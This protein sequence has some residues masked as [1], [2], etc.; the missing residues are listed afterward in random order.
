MPRG[1]PLTSSGCQFLAKY[2]T[3]SLFCLFGGSSASENVSRLTF[4]TSSGGKILRRGWTSNL[5]DLL[6]SESRGVRRTKYRG[7]KAPAIQYRKLLKDFLKFRK[8]HAFSL[9]I[10]S[11]FLKLNRNFSSATSFWGKSLYFN[12]NILWEQVWNITSCRL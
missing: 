2:S 4:L 1:T 8:K 6:T 5:F 3:W 9:A 7:S 11:N 10:S 12:L